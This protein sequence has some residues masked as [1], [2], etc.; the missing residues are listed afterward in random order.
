MIVLGTLALLVAIGSLLP[1][2]FRLTLEL[3]QPRDH[4]R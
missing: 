1:F 4:R 3:C 2:A